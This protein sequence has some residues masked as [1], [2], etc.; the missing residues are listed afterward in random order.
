MPSR[1]LKAAARA[2][3]D[4]D[5]CVAADLVFPCGA[6]LGEGSPGSSIRSLLWWISARHHLFR[7]YQ[8]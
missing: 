4:L 3:A 5:V 7:D 6:L 1:I 2:M 8:D